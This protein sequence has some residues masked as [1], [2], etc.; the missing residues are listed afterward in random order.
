MTDLALAQ[1]RHEAGL[2]V[3]RVVPPPLDGGPPV[4]E[5]YEGVPT[6]TRV[7]G[8]DVEHHDYADHPPFPRATSDG[9]PIQAPCPA[10]GDHIERTATWMW[11]Q[12]PYRDALQTF[13][14]PPVLLCIQ[15]QPCGHVVSAWG[16]RFATDW[17][18]P[19]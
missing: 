13:H 1:L 3:A 11:Q 18:P 2:R 8:G 19:G 10:C 5:I 17:Q 4:I 15:I 6:A 7:G 9:R 14:W 16:A 12:D